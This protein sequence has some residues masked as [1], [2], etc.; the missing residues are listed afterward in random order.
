M[1]QNVV[2]TL[3]N[4]G[5]LVGRLV[6]SFSG[7]T[8]HTGEEPTDINEAISYY[9]NRI[10]FLEKIRDKGFQTVSAYR[11]YQKALELVKEHERKAG[12]TS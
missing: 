10:S 12:E 9:K 1:D 11:E 8:E 6:S 3:N 5:N 7:E 4:V 2:N